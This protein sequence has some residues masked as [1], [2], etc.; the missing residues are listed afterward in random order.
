MKRIIKDQLTVLVLMLDEVAA[1]VLLLLILSFFNVSIPLWLTAVSAL[2]IGGLA[3]AVHRVIIPSFHKKPATG[4]EGML[5]LEGTVI[6]SLTPFGLIKI[7]GECWK[8]KS[9]DQN[10]AVGEEVKI[11]ELKGLTLE[12]KCKER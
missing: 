11:L 9:I 7:E 1:L 8:A 3:F 2:L 4:S 12:V 5:G 6:E 10:V